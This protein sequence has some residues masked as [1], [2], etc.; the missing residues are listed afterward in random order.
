[1]DDVSASSR[2]NGRVAIHGFELFE[3]GRRRTGIVIGEG[4]HLAGAG[5]GSLCHGPNRSGLI[6]QDLKDHWVVGQHGTGL[7]V[8]DT[9]H[10]DDLVSWTRLVQ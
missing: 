8:I 4:D 10:H 3:P 1:M 5:Q 9:H 2:S 7:I 6:N